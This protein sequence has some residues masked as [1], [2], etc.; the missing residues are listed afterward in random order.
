MGYGTRRITNFP[1]LNASSASLALPVAIGTSRVSHALQLRS[2]EWIERPALGAMFARGVRAGERSLALAAVETGEMAA[3]ERCPHH[4]FAVD[5]HS[6]RRIAGERR[7]EHLG[8]RGLRRIRSRI[9]A[10]DEARIA[11]H[12]S[13][14][15]AVDRARGEPVETGHDALVLLRIDRIVRPDVV[16]AP[17]VA[18]GVQNERGPALRLLLVARLFEHLS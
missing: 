3:R 7:L 1:S 4:A 15:R 11:E 5:V 6:A 8:E 2:G 18:V 13:P 16:V 17:A 14:D 12:R 10:D 9:D